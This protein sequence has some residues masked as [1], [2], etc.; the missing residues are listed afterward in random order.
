MINENSTI[1]RVE[2]R[3]AFARRRGFEPGK[4]ASGLYFSYFETREDAEA[5]ATRRAREGRFV[6]PV[7]ER[8]GEAYDLR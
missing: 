8:P 7:E 4:A 3:W 5:S 6:G 2:L 1:R